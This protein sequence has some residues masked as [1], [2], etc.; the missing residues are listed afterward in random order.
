MNAII[1]RRIV[2]VGAILSD[3]GAEKQALLNQFAALR[4]SEGFCVGGVV[5]FVDP[6]S[7]TPCGG[8]YALDLFDGARI[9]ISQDLG[10]GSTACNLDPGGVALACAAAQRAVE[11]GADVL[12]L[13]KFGKLEADH[14]GLGDAF[15]AAIAAEIP[16]LTTL[17]PV[18]RAEWRLFAG[19]LSDELPPDAAAIESWWRGLARG[20]VAA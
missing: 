13:T 20:S 12:I 7:A 17:K 3:A 8:L 5:E 9:R 18:M 16:V 14:Q 15:A 2:R 10:P 1:N 11:A 6:D 19:E 4:R